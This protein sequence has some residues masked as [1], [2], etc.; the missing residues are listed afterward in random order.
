MNTR[1]QDLRGLWQELMVL[2]LQVGCRD[3]I[4]LRTV[5]VTVVWLGV[6]AVLHAPLGQQSHHFPGCHR[7]FPSVRS[8]DGE[9]GQLEARWWTELPD[10]PVKY[11]VW[12]RRTLVGNF[13]LS[14]TSC[15]A[16]TFGRAL[17]VC[18]VGTGLLQVVLL[19]VPPAGW[20]IR[21]RWDPWK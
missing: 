12:C 16:W 6:S 1:F 9:M 4:Q 7:S 10:P 21:Y 11:L 3:E 8:R 15:H 13:G 17:P 5:V 14:Y 2:K 20:D 18:W 19:G